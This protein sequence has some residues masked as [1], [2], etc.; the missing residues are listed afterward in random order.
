MSSSSHEQGVGGPNWER[1]KKCWQG[2]KYAKLGCKLARNVNPLNWQGVGG[3]NWERNRATR[4][5]QADARRAAKAEAKGGGTPWICRSKALKRDEQRKRAASKLAAQ[6][7]AEQAN[8]APVVIEVDTSDHEELGAV[9]AVCRDL[10]SV[11][12]NVG[13]NVE[14]AGEAAVPEAVPDA[15][16]E[17]E[18]APAPKAMPKPTEK[19]RRTPNRE[20][21]GEVGVIVHCYSCGN[22]GDCAWELEQ[23]LEG[24]V[25][26]DVR[27]FRD[28]WGKTDHDGRHDSVMR[29]FFQHPEFPDLVADVKRIVIM[30][31][32][33][34]PIPIC[35]FCEHGKHRSVCAAE[36][37]GQVMRRTMLGSTIHISHLTQRF[38]NSSHWRNCAEC[39]DPKL[40]YVDDVAAMWLRLQFE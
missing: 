10:R 36:L 20:V 2:V 29:Q 40:T 24:A 4:V 31:K 28:P 7:A 1:N 39:H 14:V 27:K 15:L 21:A 18:A 30:G 33:G 13:L 12:L 5:A 11:I 26:V 3:P 37:F 9:A 19:A 32:P 35:F 8:I 22:D 38:R 34:L 17:A 23:M 25:W 16:P 6:Q